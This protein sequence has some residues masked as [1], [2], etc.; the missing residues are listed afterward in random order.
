M[1]NRFEQ[2]LQQRRYMDDKTHENAQYHQSL[3]KCKFKPQSDTNLPFKM[4]N[5]KKTDLAKCWK[6]C[7][8]TGIFI[9]MVEM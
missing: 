2:T 3:E 6:I 7:G 8:A 1:S 9:H 4:A 5:I